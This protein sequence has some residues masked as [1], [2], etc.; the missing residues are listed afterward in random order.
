MDVRAGPWASLSAENWCFWTAVLEKSLESP[1]DQKEIEPVHPKG[2]QPW[3]FTGRT[4]AEAEEPI[5]WPL[6]VK[7]RLIGKGSDAGKVWRQRW[8]G[9]QRV[10]YTPSPAQRTWIWA[11]S[12]ILRRRE[13]PG[14]LQSMGSQRVRHDFVIAHKHNYYCKSLSILLNK[15]QLPFCEIFVR[16]THLSQIYNGDGAVILFID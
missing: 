2:N 8:R 3:I 10:G 12:R 5:L 13:D 6:D 11:N 7:S 9:Q 15:C 4:V 14:M 16:L 1:M